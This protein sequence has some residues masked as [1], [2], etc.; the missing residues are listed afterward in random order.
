MKDK[1]RISFDVPSTL[2]KELK[3]LSVKHD[4]TMS[5]IITIALYELVEVLKE[6]KD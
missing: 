5:G 1:V 2:H 4:S 3:L 6:K